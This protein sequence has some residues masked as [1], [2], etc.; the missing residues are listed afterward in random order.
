MAKCSFNKQNEKKKQ[1]QTRKF[2]YL[3]KIFQFET[4]F[5]IVFINFLYHIFCL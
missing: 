5:L 3:K 2:E 1:I 4:Q